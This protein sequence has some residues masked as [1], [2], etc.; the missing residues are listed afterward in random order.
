MVSKESG[1]NQSVGDRYAGLPSIDK[2]CFNPSEPIDVNVEC[3]KTHRPLQNSA[4][5]DAESDDSNTKASPSVN[6]NELTYDVSS[7]VNSINKPGL[8]IGCLNVRGLLGKIDEIRDLLIVQWLSSQICNVCALLETSTTFGTLVDMVTTITTGYR[9]T[10]TAPPGGWWRHI[11]NVG[12]FCHTSVH[13]FG[14][15]R[16]FFSLFSDLYPGDVD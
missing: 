13:N 15:K 8:K 14:S 2:G 11:L 10:S 3:C 4:L 7:L 16:N 6:G 5:N 9:T 1:F 12:T